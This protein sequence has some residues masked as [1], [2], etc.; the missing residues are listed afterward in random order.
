MVDGEVRIFITVR[1]FYRHIFLVFG[2]TV[3]LLPHVMIAWYQ[4]RLDMLPYDAMSALLFFSFRWGKKKGIST[5]YME[6]F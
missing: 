2:S 1:C 3:E 4:P 6:F 5:C